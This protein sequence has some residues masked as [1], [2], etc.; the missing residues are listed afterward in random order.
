M[1]KITK[2]VYYSKEDKE[3]YKVDGEK[4]T[5]IEDKKKY[6]EEVKESYKKTGN[7]I[8]DIFKSL[9]LSEETK[10]DDDSALPFI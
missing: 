10:E 3:L 9:G 6:A 4:Q 2:D 1:V 7:V 5:P 8:S